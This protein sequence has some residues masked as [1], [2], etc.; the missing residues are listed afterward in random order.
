[1]SKHMRISDFKKDQARATKAFNS[2]TPLIFSAKDAARVWAGIDG[3]RL[4][5]PAMRTVHDLGRAIQAGRG[6]VKLD[7]DMLKALSQSIETNED[8][9][10]Y[11]QA[12]TGEPVTTTIIVIIGAAFAV[13]LVIGWVTGDAGEGD[14]GTTVTATSEGGN[15]TVNV[16]DGDDGE[17]PE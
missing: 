10:G 4:D 2:G 5:K 12:M 14:K 9:D 3:L 11:T 15:V 7:A 8:D 6:Q 17:R 13:G 1:M 16:N